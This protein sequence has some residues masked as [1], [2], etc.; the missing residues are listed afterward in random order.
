MPKL[1]VSDKT[2]N[3]LQAW[4]A[5][6][7]KSGG[8]LPYITVKDL[9]S[10]GRRHMCWCTKQNRDI[11]LQSDGEYRTYQYFIH[12]TDVIE[13]R[14]QFPLDIRET[15]EIAMALGIIH[16]RDWKTGE[17]HVMTTDF[18]IAFTDLSTGEISQTAYS[19]KYW[20]Q[21][22]QYN[23]KAQ[24]VERKNHRTWQKFEIEENYWNRR[25]IK[26]KLIT[27]K[28]AT[29]EICKNLDWFSTECD[30]Q[31]NE[32]EVVSFCSSFIA[33]WRQLPNQTIRELILCSAKDLKLTFKQAHS[34]FK[35][36]ALHQILPIKLE[37]P[38]SLQTAVTLEG[39]SL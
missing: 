1:Y 33:N 26:W 8:H 5:L 17:A 34:L 39:L 12:K 25:D 9:S 36:A 2:I 4:K 6:I 27:E 30:Y 18:L 24:K 21:V 3:R 35:F 19:Y 37:D 32:E 29:K 14:E 28:T 7:K 13:V 16:P 11:H 38:L 10:V 22:Y 20:D 23:D 15:M 31:T